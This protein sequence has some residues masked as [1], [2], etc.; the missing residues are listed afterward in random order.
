MIQFNIGAAPINDN[1]EATT[2]TM[3]MNM[4][5]KAMTRRAF[6]VFRRKRWVEPFKVPLVFK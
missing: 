3:P 6:K 1:A 2:K 4:V 5:N